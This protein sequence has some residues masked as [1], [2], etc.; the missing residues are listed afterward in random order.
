MWNIDFLFVARI[1][2]FQ[3]SA[4]LAIKSGHG[5]KIVLTTE[6]V[7]NRIRSERKSNNPRRNVVGQAEGWI[8]IPITRNAWP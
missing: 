2:I 4:K 1:R 8:E 6:S 3:R 7:N 5:R